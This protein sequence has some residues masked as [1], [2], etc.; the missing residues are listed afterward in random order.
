MVVEGAAGRTFVYI[1]GINSTSLGVV[2]VTTFAAPALV[3]VREN[4]GMQLVGARRRDQPQWGVRREVNE[5][6]ELNEGEDE[7]DDG[8]LFMAG[9][10]AEGRL[11]VLNASRASAASPPL[12]AATAATAREELKLA[13][14]NRVKLVFS[15]GTGTGGGGGDNYDVALVPLEQPLGGFAA[16]DISGFGGGSSSSSSSGGGG[17]GA[18]NANTATVV[19]VV[20]TAHVPLS[21]YAESGGATTKAY[22]LAVSASRHVY[23]FIAE[24]AAVFVFCLDDVIGRGGSCS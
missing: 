17:G 10:G 24:T 18:T 23:L 6:N 12:V 7:S 2:D 3:E 20:G 9:W 15:T 13:M 22:C 19:S 1:G 16:V 21:E 5:L 11:L 14:A 4:V 8:L